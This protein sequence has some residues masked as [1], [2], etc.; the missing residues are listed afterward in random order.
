MS[1]V[2]ILGATGRVGSAIARDLTGK[3][4]SVTLVG[5]DRSRL[6]AVADSIGVS[7]E[8]AE[9]ASEEAIADQISAAA[10]AVVVNTVGPFRQTALP[11]VRAC[12]PGGSYLDSSNEFDSIRPLLEL[13]DEAVN[14]DRCVVTGAGFGVLATESV[15]LKLCDGRPPASRVRVDA[16]AAAESTG[17]LG[18]TVAASVVDGLTSA[19]RRYED[20]KLVPYRL[21]SDVEQLH[22]P[23]GSTVATVGMASGELEAAQRAS[24]ASFAVAAS[25]Q[26]PSGAVAC[27]ILPVL[28]RVL[29]VPLVRRAATRGMANMSMPASGTDRKTSWAHALVEWADGTVRE[30]W[31]QTG[32]AMDFTSQVGVEVTQS[33]LKGEGRPGAYTP[34]A[35]LGPQLAVRAGGR[36]VLD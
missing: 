18:P 34:G 13:H 1:D 30:G 7:M 24:G 27:A 36:F 32:D 9:A 29:S 17:P 14:A 33:L 6:T 2:W 20:G 5:R 11:I 10:P 23:D 19:G 12:G 35:L 16:L 15:V 4:V 28:S 31:L 25:D 22:L 8:V 21:G 26:V 3:G